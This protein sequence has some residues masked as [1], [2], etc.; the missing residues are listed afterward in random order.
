MLVERI[1][2]KWIAAFQRTFALCKVQPG[3]VVA[4]VAES[5]SR[6]VNVE[7][8]RLALEAMGARP[9]EISIPSPALT[10]PAQTEPGFE[11]VVLR[12]GR[13]DRRL[14]GHRRCS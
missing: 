1:E 13:P 5:Q 9:F 7:L 6:R 10:G 11:R 3:E 14:R 12:P 8:A 4:I 2:H